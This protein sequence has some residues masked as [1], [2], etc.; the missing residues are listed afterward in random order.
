MEYSEVIVKMPD[1]TTTT[2]PTVGNSVL[3][4]LEEAI[5]IEKHPKILV[6]K[7]TKCECDINDLSKQLAKLSKLSMRIH[8]NT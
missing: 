2:F 6:E 8:P 7:H 4:N 1:G 3:A 5:R